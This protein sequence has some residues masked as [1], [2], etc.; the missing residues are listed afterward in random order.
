MNHPVLFACSC[1]LPLSTLV[2]QG[3]RYAT[4]TG[5]SRTSE[6]AST[7]E[8]GERRSSGSFGVDFPTAYYFRGIQ[9]ENQGL[10]AQPHLEL[11]YPLTAAADSTPSFDLVLGTWSSFH[12][13]PTGIA[14]G[15]SAWF[16]SDLYLGVATQLNDKW[17]ASGTYSWYGAP[18]NGTVTEEI[19]FSL[20]YDDSEMW[21]QD[22]GGLQPAFV[23]GF[24][25]K[26]QAD[27]GNDKG[28]Y[29]QI[30]IEPT[31][32]LGQTGSLDWTMT[33]P[34]AI[35]MSLSGYYEDAGGS[36]TFFGFFDLGVDLTT[37]LEMVP[38]RFGPWDLSVG[39]HALLLGDTT[40]QFNG[41]D[42]FEWI[43]SVGLSTTW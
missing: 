6:A 14:G 31:F 16:E 12:T 38:S 25:T 11:V 10:I 43:F 26:G 40:E 33:M 34:V 1:L 17:S 36:D 41:G 21:L 18:Q 5:T 27:G 37:P 42:S 3:P 9:Y 39:L 8:D 24:E 28:I 22:V 13:G 7:T 29:A 20:A 19:T 32:K 23:L 30:G 2:A 4:F 15:N 35:G